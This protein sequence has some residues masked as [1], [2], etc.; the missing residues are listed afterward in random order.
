MAICIE[1]I[2]AIAN[3]IKNPFDYVL[4]LP[5]AMIDMPDLNGEVQI[6]D[7]RSD[8]D[9]GYIIGSE[10]RTQYE[11]QSGDTLFGHSCVVDPS[12]ARPMVVKRQEYR[13]ANP[14][15]FDTKIMNYAQRLMGAIEARIH[16]LEDERNRQPHRLVS[17]LPFEDQHE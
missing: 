4:V 16:V 12:V 3:G 9:Y 11:L 10:C 15:P 2:G 14:L 13:P 5:T 17:P 8:Y 1:D 7:F 6:G